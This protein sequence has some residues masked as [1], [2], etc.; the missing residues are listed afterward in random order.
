MLITVTAFGSSGPDGLTV[1]AAGNLFICHASLECIFVID[2]RG[3]PVARIVAPESR[4]QAHP[5]HPAHFNNCIFGSTES[6]RKILYFVDSASGG[7]YS[8]DWHEEGGTPLRG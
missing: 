6:D 5:N 4:A 3:V 2:K 8:V 1:D 7:V